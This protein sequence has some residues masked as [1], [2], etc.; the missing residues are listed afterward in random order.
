MKSESIEGRYRRIKAQLEELSLKSSNPISRMATIVALLH[1]KFDYF[2]WTGFY[3]INKGILQVGPYQG[4]LACQELVPGKGVCWKAY[5]TKT[6]IVVPDVELFP[7]HI[8][9]DSRSKSEIAVPVFNKFNEIYAVLDIDS[10]SKNA[11]CETD[12]QGLERIVELL[13]F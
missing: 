5:S 3:S 13:K 6:T 9:C 4:P 10:A 1:H 2:F 11:F 8:A 12:S 7:D